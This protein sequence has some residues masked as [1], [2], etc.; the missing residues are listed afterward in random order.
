MVALKKKYPSL[1]IL[2]SLGG[3]GGCETCSD[4][5]NS[6]EGINDFAKSVKELRN[7]FKIDGIDLDWE[8]PVIKGYPGHTYRK[9]DAVNFTSLVKTLRAINDPSFIISF[10]AGGF[11]SYI[12]SSIQWKEVIKYV[13]FIN[14][15]S[16]DLV[17]GYSETSGHH[18]PLYST[19][20]Q[21]ESTDN[22]VNM[23]IK[24]GVPEIKLIIGGAFYGRFFKINRKF[25]IT[26]EEFLK[27]ELENNPFYGSREYNEIV[28][29]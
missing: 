15:M 12:D 28:K 5:F 9:E 6:P 24:K 18:T 22:A 1:K 2:V 19:P 17:H 26:P 23:L 7:Y 16:Y 13:D 11:T 21:K 27:T 4:V 3:W 29:I 25:M 20:Q 10:A 8:Y 14:I